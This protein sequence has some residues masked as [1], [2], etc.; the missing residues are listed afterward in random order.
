MPMLVMT[1]CVRDTE[2]SAALQAAQ[3]S[4]TDASMALWAA[5]IFFG[6]VSAALKAAKKANVATS[7]AKGRYTFS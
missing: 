6:A 4:K 2:L 5:G 3:N 1:H 7:A